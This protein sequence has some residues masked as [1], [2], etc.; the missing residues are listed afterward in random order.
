MQFEG[1]LT[2]FLGQIDKRLEP[3]PSGAVNAFR[4]DF[5]AYRT[6]T[7][8]SHIPLPELRNGWGH[9]GILLAEDY[10]LYFKER[11]RPRSDDEVVRLSCDQLRGLVLMAQ[12]AWNAISF[13]VNYRHALHAARTGELS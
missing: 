13:E 3:Y 10:V 6:L 2:E 11:C 9:G 12:S 8:G 4:V 1:G 5:A 7:W